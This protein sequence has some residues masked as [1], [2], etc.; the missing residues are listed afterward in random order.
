MKKIIKKVGSII[1]LIIIMINFLL[2]AVPYKITYQGR[3]RENGQPVSGVRTFQFKLYNVATGGEALW[4]S[5]EYNVMIS[6]GLYSVIIDLPT[7]IDWST[8][9]YYLEVIVNGRTLQPRERFTS[10]VYSIYSAD[11]ALLNGRSYDAFVST[12]AEN[13]TIAGV[14]TFTDNT[15]FQSNVGVGTTAPSS[16][17]DVVDGSITVRGVNAGIVVVGGT[18]T[19]AGFIGSGAGLTGVIATDIADNTITSAKVV[20]G[21]IVDADISPTAAISISKLATTGV[22]GANVVVSSIAV[23]AVHTDAIRDAAVTTTKIAGG[24]VT[25][26]KITGPI[27]GSKIGSGINAGNITTGNLDILR[28]PTGGNWDISSNLS[29]AG[30]TFVITT[31]GNVGIGTILPWSKLGVLGNLAVGETY[32]SLAAPAGGAIIEGNVGI[33]TTAPTAASTNEAPVLHVA[34]SATT[35]ASE[36]I[37]SNSDNSRFLVQWS[38]RVGD[39]NPAIIYP[40]TRSLRIGTWTAL[41]SPVWS[42]KMR[43]D[44]TGNVG[45]GTTAPGA[46]LEI[47]KNT[48]DLLRIHRQNTSP[49]QAIDLSWSTLNSAGNKFTVAKIRTVSPDNTAGSEKGRIRIYNMIGGSLTEV[50]MINEI[51]NVGIGTTAPTSRLHVRSTDTVAGAMRVDNP[52]GTA[53]VYVSTAGNV[54]IGTTAPEGKL[55]VYD[56][57]EVSTHTVRVRTPSGSE[58]VVSTTGN[59][60][61]GTTEPGAKLEVRGDTIISHPNSRAWLGLFDAVPTARW[62]IHT[63][64][65]KLNFD[66]AYSGEWV[67]KLTIDANTGNVGIGTTAPTSIIQQGQ[68]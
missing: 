23:N 11:S 63:S 20:D 61:I 41:S 49:S 6:T 58:V 13:Q 62:A 44:S 55:H 29:I 14:K 31:T 27:S 4:T 30:S 64:V 37:A 50:I 59:V 36:I 10:A 18:V 9:E 8:G 45:I 34:S 68:Q 43:I 21:T 48:A 46:V 3:L 32:G 65:W 39:D 33:G 25:D 53:I 16:K 67:T 51:G 40:S 12:R 22:L 38:G 17:F 56:T 47:S 60:G 26:A 19:A 7:D 54:G 28:M 42:E 35:K 5:D 52:A 1:T 24:A 2:S 66:S 15:I 57:S